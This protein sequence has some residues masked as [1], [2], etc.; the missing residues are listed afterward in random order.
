LAS[1][2]PD[3]IF[4]ENTPEAQPFWDDVLKKQKRGARPKSPSV[5]KNEIYQLGIKRAR[6]TG[7]KNG[8]ICINYTNP[9]GSKTF[10]SSDLWENFSKEVTQNKPDYPTFF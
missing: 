1:F 4:A 10:N 7:N 5:L 8:V 9:S 2:R 6:V 3:K